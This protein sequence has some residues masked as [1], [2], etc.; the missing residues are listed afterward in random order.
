VTLRDEILAYI[1]DRGMGPGQ[2][3]PTE[4]ELSEHFAVG[5]ST[6]REALKL[7]EQDGR[8]VVEH[9]RG[10]FVSGGGLLAVERPVTKYES[11]TEMLADRGISVT[12]TVLHIVER[13]ATAKEAEA[14]LLDVA[15][16][17]ISLVRLRC[18]QDES[19][20]ILSVNVIPRE[21]LPGPIA[22]RDWSG[23][24]TA[25]L[26][27][28]GHMVVSS[29]AR[30]SAA[31]LPPGIEAKHALGGHGRWLLIEEHCVSADGRR[32]LYAEDFHDAE[33]FGFQ[34]LRTR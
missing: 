25:A 19:P 17:V 14:L 21:C 22:Y 23:S 8:I 15:S 28:H 33:T 2:K 11:V 4:A 12:T 27:A 32:V 1:S 26:A 20:L 24:L 30:I 10:R 3:L 13:E 6:T 34:V 29:A 31:E 9:G 5:R 18:R 16:P 7:L